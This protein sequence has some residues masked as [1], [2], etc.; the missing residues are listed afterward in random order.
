M[1]PP[2]KE[3]RRVFVFTKCAG[4]REREAA[5]PRSVT[6]AANLTGRRANT[7][8]APPVVIGDRAADKRVGKP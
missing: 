7:R 1:T 5:A 8:A 6:C 3:L 2:E 4:K